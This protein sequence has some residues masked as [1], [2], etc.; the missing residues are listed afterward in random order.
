MIKWSIQEEDISFVNIYI[1]NRE[2][3]KYIKQILIDLKR[4]MNSNTIIVRDFN[5]PIS[6]RDRSSRQKV[7]KETLALND[8]RPDKFNRHLQKIPPKQQNLILPKCTWN[9]LPDRL[10]VKS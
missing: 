7:N 8:L 2:A 1:P 4:E 3:P 10:Y 9:I 6:L 5:I